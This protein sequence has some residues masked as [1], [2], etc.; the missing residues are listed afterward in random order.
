MEVKNDE[1]QAGPV[2]VQINDGKLAKVMV[3]VK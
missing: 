2:R 1:V 3:V